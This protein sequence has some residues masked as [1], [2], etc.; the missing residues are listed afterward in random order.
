MLTVIPREFSV[1]EVLPF[2]GAD[3][4]ER[5]YEGFRVWMDSLRYQ[6]FKQ[7]TRCAGCG[8]EGTVFLLQRSSDKHAADRAHFNLYARV[9]GKLVLMTKDHIHPRSK[10]GR[11][12][13][14]NLRTMCFPCNHAK[15]A[16]V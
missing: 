6:V 10:G 4:P 11:D 13:L 12:V 7:S 3:A 14:S 1:D 15:G 16:S 5:V 8:V 9:E 2:S